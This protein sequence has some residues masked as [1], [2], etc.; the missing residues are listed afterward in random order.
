MEDMEGMEGFEAL[1][2]WRTWKPWRLG[3]LETVEGRKSVRG[4][5]DG[6]HQVRSTKASVGHPREPFV[7][8][9]HGTPSPTV[10]AT[11]PYGT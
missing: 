10:G 2:P 8:G 11:P 1:E 4:V 9:D 5:V 3:N 6:G 7:D